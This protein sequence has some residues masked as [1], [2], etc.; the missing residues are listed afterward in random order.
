MP[1]EKSLDHRQHDI[2]DQ[3]AAVRDPADDSG[4][5]DDPTA[6]VEVYPKAFDEKI[7]EAEDAISKES[8]G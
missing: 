8:S 7:A 4:E 5:A 1:D 2:V 6:L 3:S